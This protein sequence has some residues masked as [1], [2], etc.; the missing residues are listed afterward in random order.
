MNDKLASLRKISPLKE[1]YSTEIDNSSDE[2]SETTLEEKEEDHIQLESKHLNELCDNLE[3]NVDLIE[4]LC[5]H[6]GKNPQLK[7]AK[8]EVNIISNNIKKHLNQ[9][10]TENEMCV[11]DQP[12][13][14]T[15]MK[16]NIHMCISKRFINIMQ[17]YQQ[18]QTQFHKEYENNLNRHIKIIM[19]N[20]DDD[21]IHSMIEQGIDECQL[22]QLQL[23]DGDRQT[24]DQASVALMMIK[25]QHSEI[26]QLEQD[27][28]ELYQI[29][30][31][32]ANLVDAQD[33][34]L[35]NIERNIEN[36]G[37]WVGDAVH[38]QLPRAREY[39]TK[40]RKKCCALCMSCGA[41]FTAVAGGIALGLA[42][43]AA[44]S[45]Q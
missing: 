14:L 26:V 7:D 13:T 30:V 15:R 35:N 6:I 45:I 33:E 9:M 34:T 10:K 22:T 31:D 37:V 18:I 40:E 28:A 20:I 39:K 42:P 8:H 24:K 11:H 36:S 44:C 12:K 41:L 29:F 2:D 5:K 38:N 16:D 27:I 17:R 23:I 19:P 21:D 3:S 32:M 43:L 1:E 4:K 25:E